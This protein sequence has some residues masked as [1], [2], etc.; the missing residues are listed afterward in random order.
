MALGY[1]YSLVTEASSSVHVCCIY[2]N[3]CAINYMNMMNH[4]ISLPLSKSA[5]SLYF[6]MNIDAKL[7]SNLSSH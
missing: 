4:R 1:T 6:H 7:K 3:D 5:S 2:S